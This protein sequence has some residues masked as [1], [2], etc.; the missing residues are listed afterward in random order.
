MDTGREEY[1]RGPFHLL[2]CAID[3]GLMAVTE[4]LIKI[5]DSLDVWDERE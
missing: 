3:L 5:D 2:K 1:I 4:V